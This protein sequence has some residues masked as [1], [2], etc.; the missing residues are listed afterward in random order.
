MLQAES[1][2]SKL[3]VLITIPIILNAILAL[4][5]SQRLGAVSNTVQTVNTE[6]LQ[7]LRNL[8]KIMRLYSNGVVDLAHKSI[9]QMLLW[10]EAD[11]QLAETR[12]KLSKAWASYRNRDLSSEESALLQ[13][14][15]TAFKSAEQA[16]SKL[17]SFIDEQSS[18]SI[19][20]FVDLQL[21]PALEPI[22][23][24]VKQ[25]IVIQSE[26]AQ[27]SAS[28]AERIASKAQVTVFIILLVMTLALGAMGFWLYR[29]IRSPLTVM[30]NTVT[31]IEKSRNLTLRTNL[32]SNDEFG[33]MGR[34]FD[35]MM[36]TIGE[37]INHLQQ[38]GKR[39]VSVTQDA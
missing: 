24:L 38:V 35:R 22:Q 37:L 29:G 23:N 20:S 16:I 1:V 11:A 33:D 30:L 10:K 17:E 34:R 5:A 31:D 13:Q 9:S 36:E 6:R 39:A 4:Y 19:G 7:P 3:L 26:P 15:K 28:V 21:Y 32:K 2:R 25:L 14:N 8:D 27:G 18:Y 12:Q